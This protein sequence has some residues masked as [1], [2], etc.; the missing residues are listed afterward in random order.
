MVGMSD[1]RGYCIWSFTDR[2]SSFYV[3]EI[4]MVLPDTRRLMKGYKPNEMVQE[5][6][7][8]KLLMLILY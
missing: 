7:R 2:D 3:R 4:L 8:P 1:A 5:C 6:I